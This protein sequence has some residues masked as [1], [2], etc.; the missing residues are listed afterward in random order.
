MANTDEGLLDTLAGSVDE[1][2]GRTFDDEEGGGYG[3]LEA[4]YDAVARA[5]DRGAGRFDEGVGGL[6]SLFDSEE[7]NTAG[8]G[9]TEMWTPTEDDI[10]RTVEDA[11]NAYDDA[12]SAIEGATPVWLDWI[13]NHQ[14]IVALLVLALAFAKATEGT[15]SLGGVGA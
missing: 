6:V 9:E 2:I 14:E 4:N 7:G 1:H 12:A 10:D 5:G 3:D 11:A 15:V 13:L 8:P